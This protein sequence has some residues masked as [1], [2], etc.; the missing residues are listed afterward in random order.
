LRVQAVTAMPDELGAGISSSTIFPVSRED[1]EQAVRFFLDALWCDQNRQ[2]RCGGFWRHM[3]AIQFIAPGFLHGRDGCRGCGSAMMIAVAQAAGEIRG[4]RHGQSGSQDG[5]REKNDPGFSAGW[6][7]GEVGR[8]IHN[9]A[10][11]AF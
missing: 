11:V 6:A 8:R 5:A 4:V 9:L 7:A 10:V 2:P 3:A 1:G